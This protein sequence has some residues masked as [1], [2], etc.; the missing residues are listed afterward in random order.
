MRELLELWGLLAA[1]CL[2]YGWGWL[3]GSEEEAKRAEASRG[4]PWEKLAKYKEP[5]W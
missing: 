4:G 2:G 5:R 3:G 1:F